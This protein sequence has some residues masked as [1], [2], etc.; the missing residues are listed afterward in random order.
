[1][2]LAG[3][4]AKKFAGA[5]PRKLRRGNKERIAFVLSG[6]GVLGAVQV[7]QLS[8]LVDA[9]IQPDVLIG[10]SVGALN[11]AA[12]AS[13]PTEAGAA[14]LR[15]VWEGLRTEDV[16][17]G[18]RVQRAWHFVRKGD[19]L[20]ANSGIRRLID[21]I[22]ARTFEQMQLPLEIVAANLRSGKE[23]W[24][25]SG[26]IPPAIL[27]SAAVPGIFPPVLVDGQLY[28]DGGVV[29]NVPLS[30]AIDLGATTVY[31]LTCGMA[32]RELPQIRR[33]ID[34]L[35]QAV[36]QSRAARVE[37]DFERYGSQADLIMLPTPDTSSIRFSDISRSADL[38]RRTREITLSALGSRRAAASL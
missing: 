25:N 10:A 1:M 8:A 2:T 14:E 15:R 29:N 31:V 19:H 38:M 20:Y 35:M 33:P 21:L 30:R 4:N 24:F 22:P 17:P 13:D 34:V 9:G 32:R 36:V 16:F 27:A 26:P 37:E 11:A 28:V 7:G 3:L 12:F 6:G 18:S 23:T 5:I